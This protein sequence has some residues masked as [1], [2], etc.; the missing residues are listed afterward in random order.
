MEQVQADFYNGRVAQENYKI[1]EI[2]D[3]IINAGNVLGQLPV[4]KIIDVFDDFSKR[5]M[6][7]QNPIHR[8][9]PNSGIAYIAGWCRK[10][11]LIRLLKNSFSDI[12]V[13]DSF[14]SGSAVKNRSYRALP[15]GLVIHWMAGNVPT[16]GFLSLIQGILTKN[17]NL[18]KTSS[19]S[20]DLLAR[21]LEIL[22]KVTI[23]ENH[24]CKELARSIAVIRYDSSKKELGRF[25]SEHADV[26]I[27]WGNDDSV[28]ALRSLPAKLGVM[29]LVFSNKTSLMI[30]DKNSLQSIDKETIS[31]RIATD[32]SVFEQKACASPHTLFLETE[33]ETELEEFAFL[34]KQ[35]LNN[36]LLS[37]PKT[38][39]T[40]KEV[41]AILNL[42][43]QYDMF[44]KAWYS[45]GIEFTILSD[46]EIKLGPPI[47]NRTLFIRKVD[48]LERV[49]DLITPNV[50]SVGLIAEKER[51]E[52][53]TML[54]A[55]KG[56]QRFTELG[57]MT[58]FELPWDG[59]MLNHHLVRWVS[60]PIP[61]S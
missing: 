38:V 47:G 30:I 23:D 25:I 50:Q 41:S 2:I 54:F 22:S 61:T 37:I 4:G 31:K 33:D 52:I 58:Q 34:L 12:Y 44:H 56:V 6:D 53:L 42:R 43:A 19:Q 10:S 5:L 55:E 18:I 57:A 29:D 59:Y 40:Q 28:K 35:A 9:F 16:L 7:R 39:P 45:D 36:A 26:R 32:M 17:V 46:D 11:N 1:S 49:A 14:V 13:L 21:L 60:R 48:R 27:F 24:S 15:R 20:G 3:G 8:A 51:Y